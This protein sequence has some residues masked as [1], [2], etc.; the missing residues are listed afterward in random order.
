MKRPGVNEK[1]QADPEHEPDFYRISEEH[2]IP[3]KAAEDDSLLLNCTLQGG[4]KAR[5]PIYWGS[6]MAATAPAFGMEQQP[7]MMTMAPTPVPV[8]QKQC[9]VVSQDM[10][11]KQP[12]SPTLSPMSTGSNT[13]KVIFQMPS[14]MAVPQMTG[15]APAHMQM[16]MTFAMPTLPGMD[17]A[18]ASQF[19]AGFA[20]ATAFSQQHFSQM[21]QSMQQQQQQSMQQ[22]QQA[23]APQQ[24]Q[25][26]QQQ[27]HQVPA[28][29]QY[30]THQMH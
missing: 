15:N 23:Q 24:P 9:S 5:M 29:V 13:T 30:V 1:K 28:Q 25:M 22:Q 3:E 7:T 26:Q 6:T 18:A 20:A 21:F 14:F 12:A 11:K 16:P 2:P 8:E 4:P 17:P 27:M 19:A 10:D